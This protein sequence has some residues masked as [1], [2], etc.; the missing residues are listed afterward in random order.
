[1]NLFYQF[2]KFKI[3]LES[4]VLN[5][6]IEIINIKW[7][8]CFWFSHYILHIETVKK[9]LLFFW[10]LLFGHSQ[11]ISNTYHIFVIHQCI[12]LKNIILSILSKIVLAPQSMIFSFVW[13]IIALNHL[14]ITT[15]FG[16]VFIQNYSGD[17]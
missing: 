2:Q 17:V 4:S 1:M 11:N 16:N 3:K 15:Y 10:K 12:N 6:D 7:Y 8:R 13:D 9:E 5:W 14:W